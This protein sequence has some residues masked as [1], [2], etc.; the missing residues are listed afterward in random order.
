MAFTTKLDLTNN[1]F[2]QSD[3]LTL[4]LS[5]D[6]RIPSV[7]TIAYTTQPTLSCL[8]LANAAYVTGCTAALGNVVTGATNGL[9]KTGK[10]VGL[11]GTLT[12]DTSINAD[13]NSLYVNGTKS[14]MVIDGGGVIGSNIYF[15]DGGTSVISRV[16]FSSGCT[17]L[18]IHDNGDTRQEIA[19]DWG[20]DML[21]TDTRHTK[22][23]VYAAD[24]R[25]NFVPR[26]LVDKAYICTV[27]GAT[28]TAAASAA[29]A[30]AHAQDAIVSGATLSAANSFTTTCAS[31]C[32]I[33]AS[34]GLTKTLQ[35]IT[36]GGA[37]TQSTILSG[38]Q[39]LGVNATLVNLSGS[40]AINLGGGGQVFLKTVPVGTGTLL[41]R[42]S[43]TGE[44]KL[45]S[46]SAF[47][48]IT[49]GTNGISI[50]DFGRLGLGGSLCVGTT[51]NGK[52]LTLG[53]L[54]GVC[55]ATT[56][57]TDIVLNA[58]SNGGVILKSQSG[59]VNTDGD[60]TNAIGF[61]AD[62]NG[63]SGFAAIDNRAG[64][65]QTGIVYDADYSLNYVNRSLVDKQYVDSI[66]TGLNV[67]AAVWVATTSGITLSGSPQTIDGTVAVDGDRVLVKNQGALSGDSTNG[68]Y[69][70]TGGTWYRA[71]DY[72]GTPSG[73][74]SNGDLIPVTSG[75]TQNNSLWA[76][77]TLNPIIVGVSPLA[78]TEFATIIDVVG[79]DG[80]NV[81]MLGG[82]HTICVQLG[83]GTASG[84]GLA[85]N[86]NGLCISSSI[87]G[88]GL[89]FTGNVL[90][91]NAVDCNS[92]PAISVGY[93]AGNC[94][95]VACSDINAA[96]GAITGATNGLT[97]STQVVKL[98]G[99]LCEDTTVCGD[100]NYDLNLTC[101]CDFNLGFGSGTG[102]AII[103]DTNG[104]PK[105]LQYAADYS[106]GYTLRSLIDKAYLT[107][108][109]CC[110]ITTAC[111]GLI[112]CGQNVVLGGSLT[113]ATTID[114]ASN[115]LNII[116]GISEN[117]SIKMCV[118]CSTIELGATNIGACLATLKINT[119]GIQGDSANIATYSGFNYLQPFS[120]FGAIT[121]CS[122][123]DVAYVTG[124]TSCGITTACN[125]LTKCGQN[126]VLGGSL[127]GATTIETAANT[128]CVACGGVG[129]LQ[130]AAG[131]STVTLGDVTFASPH[132]IIDSACTVLRSCSVITEISSVAGICLGVL[133]GGCLDITASCNIFTDAGSKGIVYAADYS[134]NFTSE[135]LIT[136]G[137]LATVTGATNISPTNG[138]NKNS[139]NAIGL[140]GTL[141]GNT[142]IAIDNNSF[143]ISNPLN[144]DV[145]FKLDSQN[146]SM[147]ATTEINL[148]V[149]PS[150]TLSVSST[151]IELQ[152]CAVGCAY[153]GLIGQDICAVGNLVK[154]TGSTEILLSGSTIKIGE[155]IAGSVS[156]SVLVWD[157]AD[158][159]IKT[160]SGA[161]LGDKNN[162]YAMTVQTGDII[163]TTGDTY[164]QLVDTSSLAI[165]ITLPATPINGLVFRIKD[166]SSNALT[167][168]ITVARNGNNIDGA[169]NDASIN[170]DGGALELVY[171]IVLGSWYVFSFVN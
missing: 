144:T 56:G 42:D 89:T 13:S 36:L 164:V 85:V 25:T 10:N 135:S 122:I 21:V 47:G 20:G 82:V 15:I 156:N 136:K 31:N 151:Q 101:L 137:Y 83:T 16:D 98:G 27:S 111:N 66:A 2:F 123:P 90:N 165:T 97:C 65:S 94:L 71:S 72:D 52:K 3:G 77:V 54:C 143:T 127:T 41:C 131:S 28:V 166:A 61:I 33:T 119:G 145:C 87:A 29:C 80:I 64:V 46:L 158:S 157:S 55:I 32:T 44:V 134:G 170:T 105:G 62:F 17:R 11:G 43:S 40:S 14:S 104:T 138:L 107:G 59:V 8:Q 58:K 67:H 103:T 18:N 68:I 133:G 117:I 148:W 70:V 142:T 146:I 81:T 57:T 37:L 84:C 45:T 30:Y 4:T 100:N 19:L 159:T 120:T 106:A 35:N 154:I 150:T 109:T 12:G 124:L 153:L 69:I 121:T 22:G 115:Q 23:L 50:C 91:V 167:N 125:G 163:L 86:A 39:T 9:T 113:G 139:G 74:V 169:G 112:K 102:A 149:S 130:I 6:T 75:N 53:D 140:G 126:V 38:S 114:V 63:T 118:A 93:N 95:V 152:T 132:F 88:T 79:G 171:N 161:A 26:S 155:P 108:V 162:I 110:G 76:L 160:V 168:N 99:T 147:S 141:T 116:D 24:Y 128:F 5:G 48:G 73:E 1:K 92:I 7:G 129:G 49:G 78:F 51:V 34:N 96:L 60:F